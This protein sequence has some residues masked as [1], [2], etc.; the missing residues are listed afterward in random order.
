MSKKE[1]KKKRGDEAVMGGDAPL[2]SRRGWRIVG[3]GTGVV[4][5]GFI[6]LTFADPRGQNFASELSPF[7]ILGGYAAI[8]F[9]IVAKDPS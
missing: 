6:V 8:G 7:L 2:L 1:K 4:I 3:I 9:G 5:L